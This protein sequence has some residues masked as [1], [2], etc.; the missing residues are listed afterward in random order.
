M[1]LCSVVIIV[2]LEFK[3][4]QPAGEQCENLQTASVGG[5]AIILLIS[6]LIPLVHP[7]LVIMKQEK[8]S[9]VRMRDYLSVWRTK[10]NFKRAS[11]VLHNNQ[12]D[13]EGTDAVVSDA[14][15]GLRRRQGLVRPQ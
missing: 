14:V 7:Q 15:G 13:K 3:A 10:C 1:L 4:S 5:A 11:T 6:L 9:A 8:G 12:R 2:E